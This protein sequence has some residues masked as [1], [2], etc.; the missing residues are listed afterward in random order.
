MRA[1]TSVAFADESDGEGTWMIRHGHSI[2]DM[3]PGISPSPGKEARV[4]LM[5]LKMSCAVLLRDGVEDKIL[6][7]LRSTDES[8]A[9][10]SRTT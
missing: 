9:M 3:I 1:L 2:E 5:S 10:Y 7:R 8:T 6:V 4:D